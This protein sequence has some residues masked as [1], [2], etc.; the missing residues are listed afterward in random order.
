MPV[1]VPSPSQHRRL[2][3]HKRNAFLVRSDSAQLAIGDFEP[4]HEALWLWHDVVG[5]W[6]TPELQ[7]STSAMGTSGLHVPADRFPAEPRQLTIVGTCITPS[8][9][10]AFRARERLFGEW[11]DPDAEFGL[12]VEEPGAPKK[13]NVRL[14][15]EIVAPWKRPVR[16]FGFEIP[17]LAADPVK[18]GLTP[19]VVRTPPAIGGAYTITFPVRGWPVTWE[20][21]GQSAGVMEVVNGGNRDA[22]PK[23]R[24][25]GPV[26]PGW[27]ITNLTTGALLGLDL[28]LR[29]DQSADVD[30][31]RGRVSIGG[32][33]VAAAAVG[34]FWALAPGRNRLQFTVP[35]Y[36]AGD[37]TLATC[38]VYDS[39]R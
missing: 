30:M 7:T 23:V 2:H 29:T 25:D 10:E 5:W 8:M 22:W 16:T 33:G 12:I 24:I 19:T 6:A 15:G 3:A 28:T 18:Y 37:P 32:R 21:T 20:G 36:E 31:R 39:W 9:E 34:E 4:G 27:R 11:G 26:K 1:V 14:R 17:L 38:S 35:S 13:L